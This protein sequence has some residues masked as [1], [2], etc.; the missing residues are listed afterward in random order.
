VEFKSTDIRRLHLERPAAED[1]YKDTVLHCLG[2]A[3][4]LA[5]RHDSKIFAGRQHS[6]PYCFKI[7]IR[8][9]TPQKIRKI[10]KK[11]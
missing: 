5:A 1:S 3:T 11:I 4:E 2:S 9:P 7:K 8:Q 6:V 10:G